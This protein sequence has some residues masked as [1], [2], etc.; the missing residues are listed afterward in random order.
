MVIFYVIS[1]SLDLWWLWIV[2]VIISPLIWGVAYL[3]LLKWKKKV[4]SY[5]YTTPRGPRSRHSSKGQ[6]WGCIYIFKLV[7]C[8]S[9]TSVTT[10][11]KAI[12]ITRYH[13]TVTTGITV[14]IVILVIVAPIITTVQFQDWDRDFQNTNPIFETGI[15]TFKI[16]I[17]FSRLGIKTFKMSITFL[18]LGSRLKNGN[19]SLWLRLESRL[20]I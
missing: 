19:G 7:W 9:Y 3:Y 13:P 6:C 1:F 20:L 17:L 5:I 2:F 15:E 16:Q 4:S 10:I 11:T 14:T 8:W 18:R 12:T